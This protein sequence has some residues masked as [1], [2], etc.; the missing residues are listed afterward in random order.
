MGRPDPGAP[1]TVVEELILSCN[2]KEVVQ[3]I[4][5]HLVVH[6]LESVETCA[7]LEARRNGVGRGEIPARQSDAVAIPGFYPESRALRDADPREMVVGIDGGTQIRIANGKIR[8]GS[9]APVDKVALAS[10][11]EARLDTIQRKI[12]LEILPRPFFTTATIGPTV[13]PGTVTAAIVEPIGQLLPVG[14]NVVE[15][16]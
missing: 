9:A 2:E 7:Q 8:L 6:D 4:S 5:L 15:T 1:E 11:V 10:E 3:E 14:S 13:A 12:D 16:D